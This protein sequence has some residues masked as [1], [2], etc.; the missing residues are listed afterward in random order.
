MLYCRLSYKAVVEANDFFFL[1][2]L[3]SCLRDLFVLH[4]WIPYAS[5]KVL[6]LIICC[7]DKV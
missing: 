6:M 5:V 7:L 3:R 1:I 2:V 4:K